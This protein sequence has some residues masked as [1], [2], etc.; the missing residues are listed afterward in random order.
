MR[1]VLAKVRN[2][3]VPFWLT[4][5]FCI[6]ASAAII[7]SQRKNSISQ[8][9]TVTEVDTVASF[10]DE[11]ENLS[12]AY[13]NN[14]RT[15]I[16]L[17][18]EL[19]A[20][21]KADCDAAMERYVNERPERAGNVLLL[22]PILYPDR[23]QTSDPP[24]YFDIRDRLWKSHCGSVILIEDIPFLTFAT[25][26]SFPDPDT[27]E[28][29]LL[30]KWCREQGIRRDSL[31]CPPGNPFRVVDNLDPEQLLRDKRFGGIRTKEQN[32]GMISTMRC[33]TA[34]LVG[35]LL[36]PVFTSSSCDFG[37]GQF[38]PNDSPEWKSLLKFGD[39][40]CWNNTEYHLTQDAFD[41]LTSSRKNHE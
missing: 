5:A 9:T 27:E 31:V 23:I 8:F 2:A 18:N 17:A 13:A 22:I 36:P 10:F 4:I 35:N 3:N 7:V 26:P 37:A 32:E 33:Q 16:V 1:Q 20:A 38:Y 34:M 28:I 25:G 15:V 29:I 41:I 6:V 14:P 11:L 21:E 12:L 30:L 19:L 39:S 24:H 40:I